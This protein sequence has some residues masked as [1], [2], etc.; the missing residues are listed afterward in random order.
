[1]CSDVDRKTEEGLTNCVSVAFKWRRQDAADRSTRLKWSLR[2]GHKGRRAAG[3]NDV[4][5]WGTWLRPAAESQ[6]VH[7]TDHDVLIYTNLPSEEQRVEEPS[8]CE[9]PKC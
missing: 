6:C 1:M 3:R 8:L 2:K 5:C 4:V 7:F 9:N